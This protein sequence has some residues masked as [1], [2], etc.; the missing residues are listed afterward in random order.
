MCLVTGFLFLFCCS[1]TSRYSHFPKK[2]TLRSHHSWKSSLV[3]VT[4]LGTHSWFLLAPWTYPGHHIKMTCL[5]TLL[6][7]SEIHK[8]LEGL[9]LMW[10]FVPCWCLK[11]WLP[12]GLLPHAFLPAQCCLR[13]PDHWM[14]SVCSPTLPTPSRGAQKHCFS[15]APNLLCA[16]AEYLL[17]RGPSALCLH[18]SF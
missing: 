3:P 16:R 1:P 10:V 11:E 14:L 5:L 17:C 2:V 8:P 18:H 15:W 12:L 9:W 4:T 6:P 7:T 13:C